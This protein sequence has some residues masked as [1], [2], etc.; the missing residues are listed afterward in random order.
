MNSSRLSHFYADILRLP[1]E[2]SDANIVRQRWLL[3][4]GVESVFRFDLD[5][6]PD[7]AEQSQASG[8][9]ADD[10]VKLDKANEVDVPLSWEQSPM[11]ET[12]VALAN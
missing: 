1:I 6:V 4:V 5:K 12:A 11:D 8:Q 3:A 7:Q 10:L 2:A 9:G